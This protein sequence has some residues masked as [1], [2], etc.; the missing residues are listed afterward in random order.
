MTV[1]ALKKSNVANLR[2][3]VSPEA[4]TANQPGPF[5]VTVRHGPEQAIDAPSA[6]PPVS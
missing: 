1:H 6:M 2:A 5:P 4:S 3:K